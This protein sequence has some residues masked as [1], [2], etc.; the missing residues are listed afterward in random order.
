MNYFVFYF[1]F[2]R[3]LGTSYRKCYL[4]ASFKRRWSS[5]KS[6]EIVRG[7]PASCRIDA[8]PIE[9]L[10]IHNWRHHVYINERVIKL[11]NIDQFVGATHLPFNETPCFLLKCEF[12]EMERFDCTRRAR[13]KIGPIGG[14]EIKILTDQCLFP[15]RDREH[16]VN[17]RF[18]L[19]RRMQRWGSAL[20][21]DMQ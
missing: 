13:D 8:W 17:L 14:R 19:I 21:F 16:I 12:R 15:I 4:T 10:I 18:S 20:S 6:W 5:A 1:Y 11:R 9:T 7:H 2:Q 3:F